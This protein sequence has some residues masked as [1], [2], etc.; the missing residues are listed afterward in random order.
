MSTTFANGSFQRSSQYQYP[1]LSRHLCIHAD[2]QLIK[3]AC[4][5]NDMLTNGTILDFV[6]D[7]PVKILGSQPCRVDN[8][9]IVP[10]VRESLF[11][12]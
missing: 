2:V 3:T 12:K 6:R 4:A 8:S 9:P 11:H 1:A 5:G 7:G 10:F